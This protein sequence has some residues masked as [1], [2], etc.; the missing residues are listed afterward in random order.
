MVSESFIISDVCK[1]Y[2]MVGGSGQLT[3]S[4][5]CPHCGSQITR[6]SER[7]GDRIY[8]HASSL[9]DPGKYSP[10]KS[11]YSASAQHWDASAII[12]ER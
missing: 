12:K 4:G 6:R 9:N 11:I 5:F 10:E 7:M 1:T 2:E 8:V 3:Y